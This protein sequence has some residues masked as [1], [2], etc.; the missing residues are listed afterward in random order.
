[1]IKSTLRKM[2]MD[3]AVAYA[4]L[5][6]IASLIFGPVTALLVAT[7]FSPDLQG[8][9]YTFGSLTS[10]QFLFELGLGQAIIQFASH[11]WVKLGFDA[12]R[13]IVGADDSLSRLTSLGR[14][15]LRWYGLAA[16]LVLVVLG[17][18]G[19]VFFA[20]SPTSGVNW[21]W[22][23]FA[24][25]LGVAL[26]LVLTPTFFLLQGCNQVSQFWFYRFIQQVVNGLV[27]WIAILFGAGLWASPL[28]MA[29]GLVWSVVFLLQYIPFLRTF[30]SKPA[31]PRIAWSTEV[32]PIQWRIAVSWFSTYFTSQ[33]FT[34]VLFKFSGPAVA[35]QM[36][37]TN[38]L[39]NV[40]V[41]ISSNWVVTKAPQFGGLVARRQFKSLDRT[42]FRS[43]L[44]SI[45]VACFGAAAGA[46]LI[47]LLYR[48]GSP[49]SERI[50]PPLPAT[51][52]LV[53]GVVSSA[54]ASLAVY[55]RAHKKEPLVGVFSS[56][57]LM[58]A[59]LT[60][61]LGSR[62]GALGIAIGYLGVLVAFELPTS[63][64]VFE[65]CRRAWHIA[66]HD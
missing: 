26:N 48:I 52:F 37:L 1:M 23:W 3:R 56:G 14:L 55:L 13:R 66:E 42:F 36:G 60:L 35:G 11:E 6:N 24:V 41:A 4:V 40:L 53:A 12:D 45:T 15:S 25:C 43:L 64:F 19:Y 8:Y 62:I 51:L 34:P 33:L 17:L 57:S 65:R 28:A 22:P 54:L 50:L 44:V 21:M 20:R 47:Y 39:T 10:L 61:V 31:G 59:I 49:L 16:A 27:L 30:L 38:T 18:G 32:W 29:C 5:G 58:V 7:R 9:Y 46:I 63:L 2:E